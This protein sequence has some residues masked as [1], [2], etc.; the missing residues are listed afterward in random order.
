MIDL[1][2]TLADRQ[3]AVADWADEFCRRHDQE[4]RTVEW[5][6]D[7]DNDGYSNRRDVFATINEQLGL[8]TS[9]NGLVANYR[10]RVVEL[11][12]PT[13]GAIDFLQALHQNGHKVA[14]VTNGSSQSQHAKI[15]ALGLRDLVD[16]IVVS[17][18]LGIEKPDAKMFEAAARATGAPL[19][20]AWMIGDSP[21][22]D[23]YGADLLGVQTAWLRRGRQWTESEY[24]PTVQVD[25]LRQ[26]LPDLGI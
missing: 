18:D 23:I 1:D 24:Y 19:T 14:I 9:V 5:I 8:R 17:G 10:R 7:L 16:A 4:T 26:L 11:T 2:N 3:R 25:S 15:D 21:H 12:E 13:A 22:H 6:I 20:N